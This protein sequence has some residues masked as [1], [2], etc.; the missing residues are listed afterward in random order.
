MT[1]M[2]DKPRSGQQT[3]TV[4]A[5]IYVRISSD[6][7]GAGLG[8]A[9][10]EEDCRALCDRL[11]WQVSEVYPDNDVSAYSGKKRP[12]W[13]RLNKDILGG[14][15]DA[16]ACWH[17][18]RLTRSPR[19]LEDVIDLHDKHGIQLAT[20]TGDIDLSTPTGR[21]IARALGAAARHEAEHKAERQRRQLRQ[22]AQAG[23]PNGG[24]RG[25]GYTH[26]R[27]QIIEEEAEVIREYAR[28]ALAGETLGEMANDLNARGLRTSTGR[29]WARTALKTVL[30]SARISGRREYVPTDSYEHGHRPL[31]GEI[32]AT[33]CWPAII[34]ETDS[35]RLRAL[36]TNPARDTNPSRRSYRYLL[37]GI[38][39][40]GRCGTPMCGRPH[41]SGR[42]RY[43]CHK[44]PSRPGCG[45]ITV[46]ADL[47]EHEARDRILTVLDRSP[48]MLERLLAK[49]QEQSAGPRGEDPAK[50]LREIDE[51]R[52]ELAA[53]WGAGEI[54]RKEWA[55]AKRVLDDRAAGISGRINRSAQARALA[56]F[57]ALDGDMWER[58]KHPTTTS[59]ARRALIQG[60]VTRITVQPASNGSRWDPD[61]IQPEWIA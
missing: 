37:S 41:A 9:R 56:Q 53:A 1:A 8:V 20:C 6:R 49:H 34:S 19:E 3:A 13:D 17:V 58:W 57:A 25:Y 47:A 5:A 59:S 7:E 32:T 18:D 30:I 45:R 43:I 22:A 4:R 44:D 27:S 55:T 29:P 2:T 42:P 12:E 40:C 36:L 15:V 16:I 51:Q 50:M 10:Q 52:D 26:D 11:G 21:F 61:R 14:L 35:D 31:L 38:F 48:G 28:R 60:C 33:G 24:Q 39:A 23:K 46:F 54:T